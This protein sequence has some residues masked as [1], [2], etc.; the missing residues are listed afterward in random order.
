[1]P[2]TSCNRTFARFQSWFERAERIPP[3]PQAAS[4]T[5]APH[6]IHLVAEETCEWAYFASEKPVGFGISHAKTANDRSRR[7]RV[8]RQA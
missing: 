7:A 3:S 8:G 5:L 4:L 1:M 6:Q 2:E